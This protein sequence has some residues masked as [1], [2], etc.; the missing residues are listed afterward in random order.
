MEDLIKYFSLENDWN[1]NIQY[2]Q[3]LFYL[4]SGYTGFWFRSQSPTKATSKTLQSSDTGRCYVDTVFMA[5]FR[6]RQKLQLLGN[7]ANILEGYHRFPTEHC[8]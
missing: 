4:I 7:L 3:L 8:L 1:I 2:H 5:L 6:R